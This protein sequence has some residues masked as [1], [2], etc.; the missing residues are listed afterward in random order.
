[1]VR[2]VTKSFF[3]APENINIFFGR[4]SNKCGK[5]LGND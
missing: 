2:Y 4:K 1:M 5:E 3:I